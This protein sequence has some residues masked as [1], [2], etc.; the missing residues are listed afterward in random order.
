MSNQAANQVTTAHH[1]DNQPPTTPQDRLEIIKQE[2]DGLVN[3]ATLKP[4]WFTKMAFFWRKLP[5]FAKLFVIA[6]VAA[7]LITLLVA[8]IFFNIV[9]LISISAILLVQTSVFLA[10]LHNHSRHLAK[11]STQVQQSMLSLAALLDATID[12]LT[13]LQKDFTKTH[14]DLQHANQTLAQNVTTLEENLI[15]QQNEVSKL[16]STNKALENT[17]EELT[18]HTHTLEQK[19]KAQQ[20]MLDTLADINKQLQENLIKDDKIRAAFQAKLTNFLEDKEA[21]FERL[22]TRVCKAEKRLAEMTREFEQH[23]HHHQ[24]L[25]ERADEQALRTDAQIERLTSVT[26]KAAKNTVPRSSLF[27]HERETSPHLS[28]SSR[29]MS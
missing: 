3:Q 11:P 5:W 23:L 17:Q 25:L 10:F 18:H 28:F 22:A 7:I 14:E 9:T 13:N 12:D 15:K 20:V 21:S 26:D 27:N 29:L 1:E 4:S 24:Q 2:I 19:L 8:S 6:F 16:S